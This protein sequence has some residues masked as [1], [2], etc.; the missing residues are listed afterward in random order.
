MSGIAYS[1][2]G[3]IAARLDP[4]EASVPLSKLVDVYVLRLA[5]SKLELFIFST[6]RYIIIAHILGIHSVLVDASTVI[7][8]LSG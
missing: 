7:G 5:K 8:I 1:E 3:G 6:S 2:V 4:I